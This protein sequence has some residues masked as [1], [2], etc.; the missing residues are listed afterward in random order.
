MTLKPKIFPLKAK[1][2]EN[3]EAH[4]MNDTKNY[5]KTTSKAGFYFT[6]RKI[7]PNTI[8]MYSL[9]KSMCVRVCV[10]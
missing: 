7:Q 3:L 1:D 10:C 6:T 2:K 8:Q 9:L 5:K 4:R